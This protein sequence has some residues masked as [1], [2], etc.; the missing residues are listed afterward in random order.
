MA[1]VVFWISVSI[2][3]ITISYFFMKIPFAKKLF[4]I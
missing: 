1:P 2:V 3:T 4:T